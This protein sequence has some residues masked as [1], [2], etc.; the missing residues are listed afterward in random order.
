VKFWFLL[1]L[2]VPQFSRADVDP[3]YRSLSPQDYQIYVDTFNKCH[4]GTYLAAA[5]TS[6]DP[7][8]VLSAAVNVT[9]ILMINIE[10]IKQRVNSHFMSP[11]AFRKRHSDGYWLAWADCYANASE[12]K[13][14]LV[15]QM[16]SMG[17]LSSEA[18]GTLASLYVAGKVRGQVT[19][20]YQS[21]PRVFEFIAAAGAA[22]TLNNLYSLIKKEY[23]S[24]PTPQEEAYI[25]K[26]E[27][28]MFSDVDETISKIVELAQ[29]KVSEIDA[30]LRDPSLSPEERIKLLKKR[31]KLI[32]QV[33]E[34]KQKLKK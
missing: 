20:F 22:V 24:K 6:I 19:K 29:L 9:S 3:L 11:E 28:D 33:T 27:N 16:I 1:L 26:I 25:Q 15:M 32:S 4:E 7:A 31:K 30:S 10:A 18:A 34:L 14:N 5:K 21:N 8:I 17:H 23:F 12:F 13:K 2:L